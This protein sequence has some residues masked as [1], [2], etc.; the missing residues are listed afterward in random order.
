MRDA[1]AA[2]LGHEWATLQ[3]NHEQYEK[4]SLLIKLA[5]IALYVACVALSLDLV[6]TLALMLIMWVQEGIFRTSQSR[7]GER[8]LRVEQLLR[9]GG[10]P[11][12]LHTEWQAAR[13]GFSGLLA[14]Y[15]RNMVRPT[16]A[17]PYV[18]LLIIGAT[19]F[20]LY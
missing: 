8:I 14:E 11:Y 15:G 12:Q 16:V 13:P 9:Q 17:F 10:L 18:L 3:N 5:G 2:G 19:S 6:L 1:H 7:L 20:L 4:T